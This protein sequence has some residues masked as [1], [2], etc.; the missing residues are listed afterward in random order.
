[1]CTPMTPP[2]LVRGQVDA[3]YSYFVG[4]ALAIV[5]AFP[6]AGIAGMNL[7]QNLAGMRADAS[8]FVIGIFWFVIFIIDLH[9][10]AYTGLWFGL[11][12]AR[13]DRA[14]TKSIFAVLLL[15]WITLVIPVLGCLGLIAWPVFWMSWA[16]KRLNTRFREEAGGLFSLEAE[17]S[18]WFPWPRRSR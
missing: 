12:N 3:L 18:G 17:R 14:I 7:G 15:P 4:P 1:L 13:V 8:L 10:I 2:E 11:T 9:A 6:I 5:A 16:S